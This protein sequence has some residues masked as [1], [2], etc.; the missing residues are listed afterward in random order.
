MA[1]RLFVTSGDVDLVRCNNLHC[2]KFLGRIKALP[3]PPNKRSPDRRHAETDE[4]VEYISEVMSQ[5]PWYA[6]RVRALAAEKVIQERWEI[7]TAKITDAFRVFII[8]TPRH[9]I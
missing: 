4:D 9:V 8:A 5:A 1:C 7:L 3:L 6:N 2:A